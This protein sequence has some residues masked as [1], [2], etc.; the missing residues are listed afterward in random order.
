MRDL[1]LRPAPPP[2]ELLQVLA[3]G[4]FA[5]TAGPATVRLVLDAELTP[6][7]VREEVR[8]VLGGG[9]TLLAGPGG[10]LL[11]ALGVTR[12]EGPLSGTAEPVPEGLAPLEVRDAAPV[13]GAGYALYRLGGACVALDAPRGRG[14][15]VLA[16]SADPG[17]LLA[18]LRWLC[19]R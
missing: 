15:A 8:F 5:A 1:A 12:L 13:T 19:N 17:F 11:A 10:P 9:T 4:G 16:G 7:E 6:E 3:E 18:C 14:R 2:P